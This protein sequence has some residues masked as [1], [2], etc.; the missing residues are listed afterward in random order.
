M[1]TMIVI[2]EWPENY[3]ENNDRWS[4]IIELLMIGGNAG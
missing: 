3:D 4:D 1:L 2:G